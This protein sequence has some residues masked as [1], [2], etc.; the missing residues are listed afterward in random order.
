MEGRT[1]MNK[2]ALNKYVFLLCGCRYYNFFRLKSVYPGL[3]LVIVDPGET[4]LLL[5]VSHELSHCLNQVHGQTYDLYNAV[6][7]FLEYIVGVQW[8]SGRKLVSR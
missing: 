2:T 5:T 4:L 7:K 8:L 1:W 6:L 3:K